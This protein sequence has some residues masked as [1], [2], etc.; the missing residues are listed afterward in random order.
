[1]TSLSECRLKVRF[2]SIPALALRAHNRRLVA[3]LL[4]M[5]VAEPMFPLKV[6]P[7]YLPVSAGGFADETCV[8]ADTT[9]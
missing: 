4:A 8:G 1:M 3:S 5:T 9:W 6:E 2:G 7:P